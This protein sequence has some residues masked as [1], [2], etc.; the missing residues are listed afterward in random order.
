MK[1]IYLKTSTIQHLSKS[2]IQ[3]IY[4]IKWKMDYRPGLSGILAEAAD[5]WRHEDQERS[6]PCAHSCN[7]PGICV[8]FYSCVR[9]PCSFLYWSWTRPWRRLSITWLRPKM[10]LIRLL[11]VMSPFNI[12]TF[13]SYLTLFDTNCGFQWFSVTFS[14]IKIQ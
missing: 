3:M 4:F 13:H 9:R 6:S 1:I 2:F 10:S 7:N 14:L 8:F 5:R 12:L 11:R